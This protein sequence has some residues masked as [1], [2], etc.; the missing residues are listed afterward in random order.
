MADD[1]LDLLRPVRW[2]ETVP[3]V[4]AGS[5][6]E[7]GMAGAVA[8]LVVVGTLVAARRRRIP[9]PRREALQRLRA[10]RSLPPAERLAAE[11]ALVRHYAGRVKGG[12]VAMSQ[13][14]DWL[15]ALDE[16]FGTTAFTAGD[17]R[18]LADGLYRPGGAPE[19]NRVGRLLEDL[20]T[21]QRS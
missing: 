10:A 9:G 7:A 20:L 17:G 2:P 18:L 16:L 3:V 4:D 12:A 5:V 8:A 6:L 15:R 14:E 19:D 11:A 13:G 21:R 1:P